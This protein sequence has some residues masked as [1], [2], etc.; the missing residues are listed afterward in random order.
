MDRS[1]LPYLGLHYVA[2][3]ILIFLLV[4]AIEA[5]AGTVPLWAGV[6]VAIVVGLAYPRVVVP[7][8]IAPE[9]WER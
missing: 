9:R 6:V 4:V 2:L 3:V 8:G 1:T 5:V 7:L